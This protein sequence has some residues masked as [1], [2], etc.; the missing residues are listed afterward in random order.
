MNKIGLFFLLT[1]CGLL[2]KAGTVDTIFIY[3]QAMHKN[4]TCVVIKPDAYKKKK[5]HFP[6]VYLLHGWSGKYSDWIRQEPKLKN[7]VD[8]YQ[9]LI[10]C[11]DGAFGSWYFDS[12]L[13]SNF[14]YETNVGVEIPRFIDSAFRTIPDRNHRA[15]TGLSMGGHGAFW[16]AFHHAENFG[17]VGSMSGGV[18][19]MESAKYGFD[20]S[21]R[22]GDTTHWAAYNVLNLVEHYPKDSLQIM[23]DCGIADIFTKGNRRLHEK[24]LAL[25]IKHDYTER[26]GTHNWD[27][28]RN[29]LSYHLL[30]FRR[31]FDG[32]RQ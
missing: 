24:L 7:Y 17:A 9:C 12:P 2:A 29:S 14:L 22:I 25:K 5:N 3:S 31:F 15:I 26:P 32:V 16:L 19:L 21:K 10:I 20:I 4:V 27:Y 6:V 1:F 18:D 11:P 8:E 13:D 30:F 23:F 28:W